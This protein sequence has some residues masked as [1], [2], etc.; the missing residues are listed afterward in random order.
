MHAQLKRKS[1]SKKVYDNSKKKILI[2]EKIFKNKQLKFEYRGSLWGLRE[3]KK[4]DR[5]DLI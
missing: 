1:N 5:H 3:K 4:K 2:C